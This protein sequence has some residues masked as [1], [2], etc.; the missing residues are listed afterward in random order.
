MTL[1]LLA[2]TW[3]G[4]FWTLLSIVVFILSILLVSVI[5]IQDSKD[6]G[7]GGAFGG[8]G[9]GGAL[10]GA[11][12][13]K[14]LARVTAI[15]AAILAMSLVAMGLISN[16]ENRRSLAGEGATDAAVTF[17]EPP[18]PGAGVAPVAGRAG[19]T[20]EIPLGTP[21]PIEMAPEAPK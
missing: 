1:Q 9:G 13:Q 17:P 21:T 16:L 20:I 8:A 15:F 18:L 19:E 2:W 5:L 4:V 14:D 11:R 6:G 7:L 12:M 3:A 10:M